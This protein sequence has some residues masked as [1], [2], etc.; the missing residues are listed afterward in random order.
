MRRA[1]LLVLSSPWEGLGN[2]LIESMA[3]GTSVVSTRCPGG[4][5]EILEDGKYGELVPV[6]DPPALAAAMRRALD[7]PRPA[8][9]L[10]QRAADFSAPMAARRYLELLD[11]GV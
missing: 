11:A 5:A 6:G 10:R 2:V 3:C 7:H 1:A 4:P 8:E 9:P